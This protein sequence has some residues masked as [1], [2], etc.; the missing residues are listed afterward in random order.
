MWRAAIHM[1][2]H[3]ILLLDIILS[4]LYFILHAFSS[5]KRNGHGTRSGPYGASGAGPTRGAGAG[6][7]IAAK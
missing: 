3:N 2:Q 4:F 7:R 1:S 6:N 5:G